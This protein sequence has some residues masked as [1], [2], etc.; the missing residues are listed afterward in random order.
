M[1][2]IILTYALVGNSS[3][4]V[5]GAAIALLFCYG[6]AA[7]LDFI[8]VIRYSGISIPFMDFFIKAFLLGLA[9]CL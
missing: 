2:K 9:S 7:S 4:N 1:T 5:K 3:L 6:I 8:A